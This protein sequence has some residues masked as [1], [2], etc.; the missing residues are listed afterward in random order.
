[1]IS[2][3][4]PLSC[5]RRSIF[6]QVSPSAASATMAPSPS[7]CRRKMVRLI[8]ISSTK[9]IR[10]PV[11]STGGACSVFQ[12]SPGSSSIS[13]QKV[14]PPPLRSSTPISP[15][16]KATS[17]RQIERPRPVPPNRRVIDPSACWNFWNS[18]LLAFSVRPMPV[19][20]TSMRRPTRPSAA[21]VDRTSMATYPRS[22]NFKA[23]DNRLSRIWRRRVGSPRNG[24]LAPVSR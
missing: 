7:N 5:A 17:W 10:T 16:I 24:R 13:T 8:S 15:P 14:L 19:S 11:S 6:R 4:R 3:G 1:M 12:S 21:S 20:L 9:R 23:L 22:V 2:N 18:L